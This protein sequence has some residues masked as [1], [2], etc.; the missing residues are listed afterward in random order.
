MCCVVDY[1]LWSGSPHTTE[2]TSLSISTISRWFDNA[3]DA[4]TQIDRQFLTE[5]DWIDQSDALPLFHSGSI[6]YQPITSHLTLDILGLD[7]LIPIFAD[8]LT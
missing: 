1:L 6:C 8:R 5:K 3:H 4:V 7:R 2:Y